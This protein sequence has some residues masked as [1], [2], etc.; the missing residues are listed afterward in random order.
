LRAA[1]CT[2]IGQ[3][4]Q[5]HAECKTSHGGHSR[6]NSIDARGLMVAPRRTRGA[7]ISQVRGVTYLLSWRLDEP[8]ASCRQRG[9]PA[10]TDLAPAPFDHD[11]AAVAVDPAM[12]LPVGVR[13][14]RLLPSSR[15]PV[16]RVA[17]PTMVTLHPHMVGTRSR[18]PVLIYR[19]RW[20][21]ANHNLGCQRAEG[22]RACKDQSDQSS[23]KHDA[24]YLS[25]MQNCSTKRSDA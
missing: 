7:T 12:R 2:A 21:D 1:L 15:G 23:R 13:P 14:W 4:E 5:H 9:R 25:E 19:M 22:Q 24:L 16:I 3:A 6:A 11:P 17:I 8:K 18:T 10:R 20:A